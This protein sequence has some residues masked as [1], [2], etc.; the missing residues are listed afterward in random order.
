M[1]RQGYQYRVIALGD[2]GEVRLNEAGGEGWQLITVAGR[3]AYLM[4]ALVPS[5]KEGESSGAASDA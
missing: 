3:D 4:R 1:E 2:G 5:H